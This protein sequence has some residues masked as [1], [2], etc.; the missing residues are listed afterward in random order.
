MLGVLY[1]SSLAKRLIFNDDINLQ[2]EYNKINQMDNLPIKYKLNTMLYEY[3]L[4]QSFSN[5]YLKS[6]KINMLFL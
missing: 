1:Q 3:A 2:S 5:Q 6:F 4:G